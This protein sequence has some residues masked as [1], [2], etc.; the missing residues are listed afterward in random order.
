MAAKLRKT[1][2]SS[3]VERLY[4]SDSRQWWLKTRRILKMDDPNPPANLDYQGP[5]GPAP[6]AE[7]I[8]NFFTEVS[9]HLPQV[10]PSI[11]ANLRVDH[12]ADFTVDPLEIEN[13]LP[14]VTFT[15][16]RGLMVYRVGSCWTLRHICLSHLR[17]FLKPPL[18][19]AAFRQSGKPLR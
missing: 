8:N 19:K 5:P 4:S 15:K 9:S 7:T 10:D 1:Y 11:L 2:I 3:K 6:L 14:S 16:L 13:R 18:E 12:N 17:Q